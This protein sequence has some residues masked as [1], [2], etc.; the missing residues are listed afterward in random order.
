[1]IQKFIHGFEQKQKS[2]IMNFLFLFI[3]MYSCHSECN[4]S[5]FG[6]KWD[7]M[8]NI[9]YVCHCIFHIHYENMRCQNVHRNILCHLLFENYY[10]KL[11][12]FIIWLI[13][14]QKKYDFIENIFFFS[15][16]AAINITIWSKV[17]IL[18]F[19]SVYIIYKIFE[20]HNLIRIYE[21]A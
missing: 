11:P 13:R 12:R 14:F 1:M 5:F 6:M 4:L 10:L 17:W 2:Y 9:Y 18:D 21:T 8:H 16:F 20:L 7:H 19:I 3:K 15:C